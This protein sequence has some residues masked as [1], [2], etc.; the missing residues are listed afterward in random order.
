[1]RQE[2]LSERKAALLDTGGDTAAIG[3]DRMS[4]PSDGSSRRVQG[5][6][7]GAG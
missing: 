4:A 5:R 7:P 6:A 1:M 3:F 2:V